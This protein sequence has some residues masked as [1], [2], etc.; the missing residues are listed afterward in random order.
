MRGSLRLYRTGLIISEPEESKD[1]GEVEA[2]IG[3]DRL[4]GECHKNEV[5]YPVLSGAI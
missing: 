3:K 1:R 4:S 5:V 2:S